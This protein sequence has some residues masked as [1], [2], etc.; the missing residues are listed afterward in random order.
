M[1]AGSPATVVIMTEVELVTT[2]EEVV[3]SFLLSSSTP[4]SSVNAPRV[5][6]PSSREMTDRAGGFRRS[7]AVG[8]LAA[9]R[10]AADQRERA[11]GADA[12][13]RQSE[14]FLRLHGKTFLSSKISLL[15]TPR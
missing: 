10:R 7:G 3:A 5:P 15:K 14:E 8:R 13:Q 1:E 2:A 6:E 9:A 11:D 4:N 12:R